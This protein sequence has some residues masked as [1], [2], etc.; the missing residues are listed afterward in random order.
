MGVL[1]YIVDRGPY[2][3]F[4]LLAVGG[5]FLMMSQRNLMKAVVGLYMFQTAVILQFIALSFRGDA[6]VPIIEGGI[7]LHN[8]LPH[9]MMLTAIVVGVATLGVAIA[10]LR[11]IQAEQG[12]IEERVE[13]TSR[14]ARDLA[15]TRSA[16]GSGRPD[17]G[18][19]GATRRERH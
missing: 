4:V 3:L 17:R 8:P 1:H 12:H 10:L 9:A 2:L 11:R 16:R 7:T 5:V 15:S 19:M 14:A 18:P 13:G 6:S